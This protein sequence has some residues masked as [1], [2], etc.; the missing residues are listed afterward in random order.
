MPALAKDTRIGPYIIIEAMNKGGMARIYRACLRS[1]AQEVALKVSLAENGQKAHK[2][3]LRQEADLLTRL[4]DPGIIRLLP[5]PLEGAKEPSYMARDPDLPGQ[6]W[7]YAMEYL[8]GGSLA[9]LLQDYERLPIELTAAIALRLLRT[10]YYIHNRDIVHLDIKPENILLR[11]P[12]VKDAL[13]EP[14]LIDF[15]VAASARAARTTG[16][17]LV[18][19]S[20]EYIRSLRGELDPQI[21]IDLAKVDIY[22]LGV[23]TYRMC[24][25]QYPFGGI[26]NS[27][28]TSAILTRTV[29]P[30]SQLANDLPPAFDQLMR[31]WL[32]KNPCDRPGYAELDDHLQYLARGLNRL[33]WDLLLP[34]KNG[35][36]FGIFRR[37]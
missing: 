10:L 25:G 29:T 26:S 13:I 22:A 32:A 36:L 8:Q 30:P 4:N 18:T 5:L 6:P 31:R 17:T 15:G 21:R 2:N 28:L 27:G 19:M 20:P 23:V 37:G 33:P 24:T 12:P 9:N 16:G 1:S 34:K 14:V 3:A 35:G 7:Y 11:Y